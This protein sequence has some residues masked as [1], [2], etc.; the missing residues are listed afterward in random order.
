MKTIIQQYLRN[1]QALHQAQKD[2][3]RK[4]TSSSSTSTTSTSSS[5]TTTTKGGTEIPKPCK[6]MTCDF[7]GTSA[8]DGY[9]SVCY[10]KRKAMSGPS[11]TGSTNGNNGNNVLCLGGCGFFGSREIGRAVQQECRDRSRMPSSA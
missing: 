3:D 2:L 11:G 1:S 5:T 8:S 7:N 6:T 4:P 10:K 9:C